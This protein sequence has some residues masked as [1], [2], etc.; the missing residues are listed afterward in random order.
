MES[1]K[2]SRSMYRHREVAAKPMEGS[3][4]KQRSHSMELLRLFHFVS[5]SIIVIVRIILYGM[6]I[7]MQQEVSFTSKI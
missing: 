6:R 1:S 5:S 7:K 2:P 4:K 3:K